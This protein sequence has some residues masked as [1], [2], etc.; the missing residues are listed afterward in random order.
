MIQR[1]SRDSRLPLYEQLRQTLLSEIRAGR[2]VTGQRLESEA[3][4][5]ARFG[6]SRIVVRQALGELEQQGYLTRL[7]GK[8]TFVGEPKLHEHLLHTAGGFFHDLAAQGRAVTSR[9]LALKKI[10]APPTVI[11]KLELSSGEV[12][13]LERLRSVDGETLVLTK[14]YLPTWLHPG[15]ERILRETDLSRTSL[16]TLLERE[17][18]IKVVAATR[19][20]EA[21]SADRL[22]GRRLETKLGAPLLLLRSIAEDSAKRPVE[23]FEAWHRGDRALFEV[24][25]RSESLAAADPDQGV[26]PPC[27]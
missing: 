17:C 3:A 18:A 6:I 20:I 19:T 14:S 13:L 9:V 22:L 11:S 26:A 7:Q 24:S 10:T 21:V 4:L 5:C 8:G 23:Y 1:V 15:L 12:V 27:S 16:Y 2:M 25:V